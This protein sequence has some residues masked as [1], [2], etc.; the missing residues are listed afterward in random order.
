MC[1]VIWYVL[2]LVGWVRGC[3]GRVGEWVGVCVRR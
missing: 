1:V 3:V 2:I